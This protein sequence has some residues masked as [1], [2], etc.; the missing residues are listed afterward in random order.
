MG[1][2]I[3]EGDVSAF[4]SGKDDPAIVQ[5]QKLHLVDLKLVGARHD[6]RGS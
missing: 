1:A 6:C 4:G 3:I 2:V 5:M